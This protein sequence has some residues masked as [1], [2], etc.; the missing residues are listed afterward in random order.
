MN[1]KPERNTKIE[2][3]YQMTFC[4]RVRTFATVELTESFFTKGSW[5]ISA[6]EFQRLSLIVAREICSGTDPLI[7]EEVE[8][9]NKFLRIGREKILAVVPLSEIKVKELTPENSA[10]LRSLFVTELKNNS[11]L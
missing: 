5:C 2:I 3:N 4:G 9:L 7:P 1:T 10:K 8:F 6:K 11:K